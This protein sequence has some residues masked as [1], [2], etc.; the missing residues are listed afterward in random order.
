MKKKEKLFNN[1]F[2]D[3]DA[4]PAWPPERCILCYFQHCGYIKTITKY[5][6]TDTI[7]VLFR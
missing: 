3:C 2:S 6:I 7:H 1:I 4:P 5:K